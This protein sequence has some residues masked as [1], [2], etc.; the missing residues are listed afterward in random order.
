MI[1]LKVTEDLLYEEDVGMMSFAMRSEESRH[2]A[3]HP[4]MTQGKI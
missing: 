2:L 3:S 1:K 4:T